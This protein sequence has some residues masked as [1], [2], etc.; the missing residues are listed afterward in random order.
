[1]KN[2]LNLAADILGISVDASKNEVKY[3]YYRLMVAYHP[4]KH[5]DDPKAKQRSALINEAKEILLGKEVNPTMLKD[6]QLID[7]FVSQPVSDDQ[8]MSYREWLKTQFYNMDQGSIW[9]C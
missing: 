8:I 9:P 7:E 5:Q 4:D 2:W 6:T 3:A 1:M